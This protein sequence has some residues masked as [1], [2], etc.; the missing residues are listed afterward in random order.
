LTLRRGR[1]ESAVALSALVTREEGLKKALSEAEAR[2]QQRRD[3]LSARSSRLHSLKELEAQ[4]AGYGR[5]I[6]TLLLA[7]RFQGRFHGMVA[8]AVETDEEFEA[9]VEAVLGERLQYLLSSGDDDVMEAIGFL[10]E[11]S[12]TLPSPSPPPL[13]ER[14]ACWLKSALTLI[15]IASSS[16]FLPASILPMTSAPPSIWPENSLSLPLSPPRVNWSRAP[17]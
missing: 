5:G 13:P 6:R 14:S 2:L 11:S 4:F 16:R 8:D 10:K 15:S 12:G 17:G 1:E 7:D 9:A 3:E